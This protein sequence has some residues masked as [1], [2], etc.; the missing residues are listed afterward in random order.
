[1]KAATDPAHRPQFMRNLLAAKIFIIQA[2][3]CNLEI[4]NGVAQV[5]GT[6]GISPITHAEKDWLPIF[7]SLLR[8]EQVVQQEGNYLQLKARDFFEMT[9]GAHVLMNPGHAY[10]KEFLPDEI[11]RMIDGTIFEPNNSFI[12][13][14]E[15]PVLLGQPAEYPQQLVAALGR[16]FVKHRGVKAAYLAQMHIPSSGEPPHLVVG[17]EAQGNFQ[18]ISGEV[19]LVANQLIPAGDILDVVQVKAYEKGIAEYLRNQTKPF[20]RQS[21]W[22]RM[23]G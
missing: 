1:M 16:L 20:Y 3:P 21:F 15:T 17:I 5:G 10:G 23:L 19:G 2:G 11:A 8:L 7:T 14:E 4:K 6:I 18:R 13:K 12:V 9:R 22:R